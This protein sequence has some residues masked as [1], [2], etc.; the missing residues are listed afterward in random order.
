MKRSLTFFSALIL[1]GTTLAMA[2]ETLTYGDGVTLDTA[3]AIETLMVEPDEY[4]GKTVRVD[5]VVTGVCK[6]RG[7]W[8][9]IT[10]PDTG[11]GVRVKVEDGVI[12][13]PYS[14]MGHKASAQGV[15]EAIKLTPEQAA[16]MKAQYEAEKGCPEDKKAQAE[17][18]EGCAKDKTGKDK[19]EPSTGCA[20]QVHGDTIYLLRGTGA[21]ISS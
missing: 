3:T 14:V 1:A 5:G 9:H 2:G 8:I 10:D 18:K 15:F 13:F 4:A 21:I 19:K 20:P 17:G 11:K 12:V 16:K 6:N 7:C